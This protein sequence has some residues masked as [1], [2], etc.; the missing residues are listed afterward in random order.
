VAVGDITDT[1]T[2]ARMVYTPKERLQGGFVYVFSPKRF[3]GN[4]DCEKDQPSLKVWE[5]LVRRHTNKLASE[6][7]AARLS[8]RA[9]IG[10]GSSLSAHTERTPIWTAGSM[11]DGVSAEGEVHASI[12]D[13]R[14]ALEVSPIES[15]RRSFCKEDPGDLLTGLKPRA[16]VVGR[17]FRASGIDGGILDTADAEARVI[18]RLTARLQD[19]PVHCD[20]LKSYV[21]NPLLGGTPADVKI[22]ADLEGFVDPHA[23]VISYDPTT[24]RLRLRDP[25]I[26]AQTEQRVVARLTARL[27]RGSASVGDLRSFLGNQRQGGGPTDLRVVA[28]FE[29]FVGRHTDTFIYDAAAKRLSLRFPVVNKDFDPE[30]RLVKRMKA[31]LRRGPI[32]FFILKTLFVK[33]SFGP[34][35]ERLRIEKILEAF[36]RRHADIF[37]YDT[38]TGRVSLRAPSDDQGIDE[39]AEARVVRRVTALLQDGPGLIQFRNL[40][41][42]LGDPLRGGGP[43]D[44]R[45]VE[46]IQA[47]IRRHAD[48]FCYDESTEGVSLRA[49]FDATKAN[50]EARVVRQLAEELQRGPVDIGVVETILRYPLR[51]GGPKDLEVIGDIE[52]FVL[53]HP[54][55]FNYDAV[56]KKLS[57]LGSSPFSPSNVA[58]PTEES[59]GCTITTM[60]EEEARLFQEVIDL[61]Q[62]CP[63]FENS[64]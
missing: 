35:S 37:S 16:Y 25:G 47:F 56:T 1:T 64:R 28:E 18:Q 54:N 11:H 51:G 4:R 13:P 27:Q 49:L 63:E 22:V 12:P 34:T 60:A 6:A 46:D 2:E 8:L 24:R 15:D 44:L 48:T 31:K 36:L 26:D 53:R 17:S 21:G 52:M 43:E 32:D 62:N 40:L 10:I 58:G 5:V 33:R 3:L 38:A 61:L 30:A 7:A 55:T 45:V 42:N 20:D 14:A 59:S 57:L 50:V 19:G 9:P 23:D 41:S 29:A 39:Q